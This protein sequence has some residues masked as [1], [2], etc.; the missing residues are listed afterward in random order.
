M[1][2]PNCKKELGIMRWLRDGNFVEFSATHIY[3][4]RANKYSPGMNAIDLRK[5]LKQGT[6][7]EVLAQSNDLTDDQMDNMIIEKY[8]EDV[9]GVFAISGSVGISNGDFETVAS[10]IQRT[11]KGVM[12]WFYFEYDEWFDFPVVKHVTTPSLATCR[13]SVIAVDYTLINGKKYLI[14]DDS[15]GK[16]GQFEG[17]RAISEEFFNARN[18]YAN[19]LMNFKF[20]EQPEKPTFTFTKELHYG[21]TNSDVVHLQDLLRS[22][23]LFPVNVQSTGY[24]GALTAEAVLKFQKK[25]F[26]ASINELDHLQGKLVGVKTIAALNKVVNS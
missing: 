19:Y 5:I 25:Y 7:L 14:I 15:W 1:C 22:L 10:V 8:K 23:G 4:R 9:G 11:G 18:F 12:V 26:V 2:G 21:M 20:A 17:Q 16:F 13:H 24:Y 3:Q 6:T